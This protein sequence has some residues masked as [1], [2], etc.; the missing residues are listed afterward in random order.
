MEQHQKP[1][2][3]GFTLV[4]SLLVLSI[5]TIMSFVLIVNIFPIYH[6]K[7]IETFL[8]QFEK[9]MMYAQQYALVNDEPVYILFAVERN[10][11]KIV[12]G[13]SA[14]TLLSS[15]YQHKIQIEGVTLK[16]RVTFNS[17]GSIQKSGTMLIT[18]NGS[19]YKVIFYLGKGRM[20]IEKL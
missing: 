20:K 19:S 12:T 3:N 7:V 18:Y 6:E 14:K 16:N 10:Q 2:K 15:N 8:E 4:E 17:N 1:H 11:Y 5:V 13:E 9:D